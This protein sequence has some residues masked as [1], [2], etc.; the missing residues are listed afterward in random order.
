MKKLHCHGFGSSKD[1]WEHTNI[2][3]GLHKYI[4]QYRVGG[5]TSLFFFKMIL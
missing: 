2:Q 3:S 1:F 4:A 5:I